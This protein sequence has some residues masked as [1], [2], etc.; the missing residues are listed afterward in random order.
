MTSQEI[1][2]E[3]RVREDLNH[4]WKVVD[5]VGHDFGTFDRFTATRMWERLQ[6]EH[7]DRQIGITKVE[8]VGSCQ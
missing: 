3:E 1:E 7:P 8:P 4:F 6:R 2:A 5:D